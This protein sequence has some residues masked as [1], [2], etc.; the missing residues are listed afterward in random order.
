[1]KRRLLY[2]FFYLV[3]LLLLSV[4]L[5]L[6]WNAFLPQI[7]HVTTITYLQAV[8]L[9]ILCRMLFGGFGFSRFFGGGRGHLLKHR[10]DEMDDD[11]REAF[12]REWQR[13]RDEQ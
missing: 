13:R 10:L 1:M 3:V 11:T 5:M 8:A 9:M 12:K 7:F 4:A 6:L 2:G